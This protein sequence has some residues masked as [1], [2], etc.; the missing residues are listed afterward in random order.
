MAFPGENRTDLIALVKVGKAD[1][2][3]VVRRRV[4]IRSSFFYCMAE[5]VFDVGKKTAVAVGPW[6][7]EAEHCEVED[8]ERAALLKKKAV[9]SMTQFMEGFVEYYLEAPAVQEERAENQNVLSSLKLV[10][11]PPF[12][13]D[14]RPPAWKN[15]DEKIQDI[16]PILGLSEESL[17]EMRN[18]T[19]D[20]PLA[21]VRVTLD[22]RFSSD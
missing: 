5:T 16:L 12:R 9:S 3:L 20:N 10:F 14:T 11:S 4:L 19:S 17:H 22:R 8:D 6:I 13:K 18:P 15:A 1:R 2:S 7:V 21:V